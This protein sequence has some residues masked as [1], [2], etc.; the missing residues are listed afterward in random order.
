[1]ASPAQSA[2][3]LLKDIHRRFQVAFNERNLEA[4]VAMYEPDAVFV[5]PDGTVLHGHEQIRNM[6]RQILA[7]DFIIR[8]TTAGLWLG[9]DGVA[10]MHA[11]WTLT[12]LGPDH[13]KLEQHGTSAE[14]LRQ[15]TNGSWLYAVDNPM[16]PVPV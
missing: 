6:Y 9:T 11:E 3:M 10:L 2:G 8:L 13:Q 5:N 15:Q 4:L 12:S 7:T 1:M 16:V 14:V